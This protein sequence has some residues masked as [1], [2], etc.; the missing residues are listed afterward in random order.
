MQPDSGEE[1]HPLLE[2][3]EDERCT[4][5]YEST[6]AIAKGCYGNKNLG[7]PFL[8]N[9]ASVITKRMPQTEEE[10]LQLADA[11]EAWKLKRCGDMRG[12]LMGIEGRFRRRKKGK[13]SLL[14]FFA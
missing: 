11:S 1:E 7:R 6:D 14:L 2:E 12:E 5:L 8:C 13:E 10:F 3:L 9:L 4:A